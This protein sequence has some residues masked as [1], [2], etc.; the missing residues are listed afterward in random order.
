MAALSPAGN[1]TAVTELIN[2]EAIGS[3]IEQ[4]NRTIPVWFE[5]ARLVDTTADRSNTRTFPSS[6][7]MTVPL[8]ESSGKTE[9]DEYAYTA[10]SYSE[11]TITHAKVGIRT[12]LSDEALQDA[13][14]NVLAQSVM[15]HFEGMNQQEDTD[16]LSNIT[17]ATN[18]NDESGN[19]LSIAIFN[20]TVG[21]IR[22]LN[23]HA[24]RLIAVLQPIQVQDLSAAILASQGAIF[25]GQLG[26]QAAAGIVS[27]RRGFVDTY[28]GVDIYENGN[29]PQFDAS[30]WSGAL[31]VAGEP[32]GAIA[33]CMKDPF[34]PAEFASTKAM[35]RLPRKHLMSMDWLHGRDAF[36]LV[37]RARYGTGIVN[38]NHIVELI[39]SKT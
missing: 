8:S 39:T 4:L 3:F 17:S 26:N 27:F 1:S 16:F 36:D 7:G 24:G 14:G 35:R 32:H 23:P 28:Q 34:V 9:T 2:T 38:Q 13:T 20:E 21:Q 11:V 5:A 15:D 33:M 19:D 12:N 22:A 6:D 29:V 10:P 30:N 31:M 25:G 18:A 37:T